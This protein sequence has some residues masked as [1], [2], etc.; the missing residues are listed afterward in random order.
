MS[1]KQQSIGKGFVILSMSSIIVKVISLFFVPIMRALLG[2][3]AGY[4][5]FGASNEVFAFVYVLA[6]AGLPVAISKLI[7]ELTAKND[8]AVLKNKPDH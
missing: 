5:V 2:G 8:P 4:A 7:T 3:A 6:T 1:N